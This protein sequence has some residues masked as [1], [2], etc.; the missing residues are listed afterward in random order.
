MKL[1]SIHLAIAAA[2]AVAAAGA[3]N[4]APSF[5]VPADGSA[6][7]TDLSGATSTDGV[8]LAALIGTDAASICDPAGPAPDVYT[9]ESQL[10]FGV[11]LANI[12]V[13]CQ[14][15]ATIAGLN[16][17]TVQAVRKYSGGSG[18]GINNVASGAVVAADN[19]NDRQWTTG[20]GC[21]EQNGGAAVALAPGLQPTHLFLSCT[22]DGGQV[23]KGGISD[24][25]PALLGATATTIGQLTTSPGIAVDFAPVV[26]T[27]LFNALQSAQHLTVNGVDDP[28]NMPN[29]S[30][31]QVAGILKGS[32]TSTAFLFANPAT[33]TG[34]ATSLP[35]A[36]GTTNIFVCRRGNSSGTQTGFG[37]QYLHQ[38][39]GT[40]GVGDPNLTF[41][42]ATTTTCT[43][44]GCGW[45]GVN[46]LTDRVFA[47][48]GSQDVINC[49]NFHSGAG[50]Y[51][52]GV[53]TTEF[54]PNDAQAA[55]YRHVKVNGVAPSL[56]NMQMGAWDFFTED[57]FNV[58]N[59]TAPNFGNVTND[60]TKITAAL[61]AGFKAPAFLQLAL[62]TQGTSTGGAA[63][64]GGALAIPTTATSSPAPQGVNSV[65]ALVQATPV[66]SQTRA[67]SLGG[68]LNNCNPAWIGTR[69]LVPLD[70][71]SL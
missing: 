33:D 62:I 51:A 34:A 29:L 19:A 28:A 39:C 24:E 1:N 70:S 4:A 60:Q 54:A 8:L 71:P 9:T 63:W 16:N 22:P 11:K 32:I 6:N 26:S 35:A 56:E 10:T 12:M 58:P 7:L 47:G 50:H 15:R 37:I 13:V 14:P 23:T 27:A 66:N 48:T 5:A 55:A 41:V 17:T 64:F 44:G 18:S 36:G 59:A 42:G 40:A 49:M 68:P 65:H 69:T 61:L 21:T 38:G 2:L 30:A 46:F 43:A 3:A 67:A 52:I 25:E 20:S 45:D 31:G 53:L 57:A